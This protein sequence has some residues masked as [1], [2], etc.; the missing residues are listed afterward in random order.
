MLDTLH[1]S[2]SVRVRYVD[3][4]RFMQ[5]R[6]ACCHFPTHSEPAGM[7]SIT[8]IQWYRIHHICIFMAG[9]ILM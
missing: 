6:L 4:I 2:I 3:A 5:T 9:I 8:Y 7:I 1:V